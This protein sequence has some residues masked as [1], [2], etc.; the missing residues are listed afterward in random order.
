[1]SDKP[2]RRRRGLVAGAVV[3][4]VASG[5]AAGVSLERFLVG[6]DRG[7][8]DPEAREP[9]GRLPGTTRTVTTED[10][11][12]LH[13]EEV[14][15]GD[16]TIVFVHG[17]ALQ[18]ASWHYQ[19]RDLADVGRL[20]FYDHRSH[21]RSGRSDTEHCTIDQ[22]GH[23]LL[24]VVDEVAPTGPIVLVGH[25][26]GGMTIMAAAAHRP[27]MFHERV[28]GVALIGTSAGELR[29]LLGTALPI[30]ASSIV[31]DKVMPRVTSLLTRRSRLVE[32]GRRVGSDLAYFVARRTGFGPNPSPAQVDFVERMIAATHIEV[33]AAFARTF[34]EHE[35]F[36]ALATIGQAPVLVLVGSQDRLTP[37]RHATEIARR[38]PGAE[39]VALEGAGHMVMLE[40][41]PLVNLHLRAF[42]RRATRGDRGRARMSRGA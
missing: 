29:E 7:R 19:R 25:S 3:G 32:R 28:I 5:V 14:G 39:L 30:E 23:D 34:F 20:V 9:F 31:T 26:M 15:S 41:A 18:L 36:E 2:P 6:R 16:L 13:V 1:V 35:K 22:L 33:I 17:F 10:G 24:R 11:V 42:L 27:E 21:G 4:A 38:T 37:P 8:P 40:R 12:G